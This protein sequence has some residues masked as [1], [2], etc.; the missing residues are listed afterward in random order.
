VLEPPEALPV[1]GVP[2]AADAFIPVPEVSSKGAAVTLYLR[3]RISAKGEPSMAVSRDVK[4]AGGELGNLVVANADTHWNGP[5]GA[6]ADDEFVLCSNGPDL[7]LEA[8]GPQTAV[9]QLGSDAGGCR[10]TLGDMIQSW[11]GSSPG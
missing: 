10:A 5:A 8:T 3:L 6:G 11:P 4:V 7:Y 1:E 9:L 2:G